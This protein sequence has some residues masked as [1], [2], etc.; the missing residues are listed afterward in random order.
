MYKREEI[1]DR[2]FN[3]RPLFF[4]AI[5]FAL[6]IIFAYLHIFNG[7]SVLWG[8]CL[9]PF[10]AAPF[11]FCDN[12]ERVWKTLLAVC[13]LL[14]CF[15]LGFLVFRNQTEKFSDATPY[16]RQA[17]VS[18]NVVVKERNDYN[19]L[20]VLEGIHVDGEVEN[21]RLVAYLP[22]G[23]AEKLELSDQLLLYGFIETD[24]NFFDEFGSFR[25]YSIRDDLRYVLTDVE[26]V[27]VIGNKLDLFAAM[28]TRMERVVYAGMYETP[29]AVTMAVLTGNTTGIESELLENVRRG[30]IAHI[31]AVSGLHMGALYAFCLLL[32]KKTR[33]K[34][35]PKFPRYV[36]MA[37]MLFFYAGVCGFSASVVRALILC[38]VNYAFALIGVKTD[39]LESLGLAAFLILLLNPIEL[40]CVGFLLSFAACLGIAFLAKPIGHVCDELSKK[41]ILTLSFGKREAVLRSWE[42]QEDAPPSIGESIRRATT[43]FLSVTLSAQIATAPIQLS[44]FGY[45]SAWSLLLNFLF[46]PLISAAFS[47]LLLLV[48]IACLLSISW[49]S[50]ILYFP[51]M[52]WT[53]VLLAFEAFDFSSF[54]IKGV[55]LTGIGMLCYYLA[56]T[57][58]SDKWNLRKRARRWIAIGLFAAFMITTIL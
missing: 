35:M 16:R 19:L 22:I 57:F 20:L 29:A 38:L 34:K 1:A 28:R 9:L 43:S 4:S 44:A 46:V 41:I 42:E 11:C 25:A 32:V 53:G 7:D 5:L 54:C 39:L 50:V 27:S 45:L 30:G 10:A 52:L 48:L 14:I 56:C 24:T 37:S 47:G 36:L 21:G 55:S 2:L 8:L 26:S 31:F 12:F 49:S 17:Y 18:G 3:F 58:L 33:L 13:W 6:G 51:S 40:F 23:Y 15:C